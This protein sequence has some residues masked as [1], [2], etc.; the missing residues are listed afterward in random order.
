M[1]IF[2]EH[3][4]YLGFSWRFNGVSRYFTF[5][6]LPF[7]LSSAC[8][9]FTKLLRPL[10][11]RSRSMIHSSFVHLVIDLVRHL[12]SCSGRRTLIIPEWPSASFWPFLRERSSQ[13]KSFAF[14]VFVLPAIT[15]L[16]LEAPGQRQTYASRLL[17]FMVAR[18]SECWLCA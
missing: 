10:V 2:A 16:L 13:F 6:V 3:Q 4:T 18:S 7:G 15:E 12:N 8:F 11:K 1:D 14:D 5:A 17:F 9:C